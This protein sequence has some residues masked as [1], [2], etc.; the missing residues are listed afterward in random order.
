MEKLGKVGKQKK[1]KIIAWANYAFKST[2]FW[3]LLYNALK[4]KC[5]LSLGHEIQKKKLG[6]GELELFKKNELYS[7]LLVFGFASKSLL[8]L[9]NKWMF[10]LFKEFREFVFQT[11]G[12]RIDK[13][14]EDTYKV[15]VQCSNRIILFSPF[16]NLR[17]FLFFIPQF[18]S[19]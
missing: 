5:S 18:C 4:C 16:Y 14:G 12:Y 6:G 7:T 1:S 19:C 3:G 17:R 10:Q 2:S 8:H 15:S 13:S 11:T 9:L